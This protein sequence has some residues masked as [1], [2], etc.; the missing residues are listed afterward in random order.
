MSNFQ[1]ALKIEHQ[2]VWNHKI[3]QS[4][5]VIKELQ[6]LLAFLAFDPISRVEISQ[7]AA[8]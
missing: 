7:Q 5:K 4:R 3:P 2:I 6:Q 1:R 8:S